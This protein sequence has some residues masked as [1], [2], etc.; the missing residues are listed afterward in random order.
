MI[1]PGKIYYGE[2]GNGGRR[3]YLIESI[4]GPI[5]DGRIEVIGRRYYPTTGKTAMS[6]RPYY[7]S[8][9]SEEIKINA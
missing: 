6:R 1:E 3:A 2:V 5:K 9:D 4:M 7:L 8:P